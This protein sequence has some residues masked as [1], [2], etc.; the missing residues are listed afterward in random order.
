M[1]TLYLCL[2][3]CL[4]QTT[5]DVRPPPDPKEPPRVQ[6]AH[7]SVHYGDRDYPIAWDCEYELD[8]AACDQATLMAGAKHLTAVGIQGGWV[9]KLAG[10]SKEP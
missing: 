2:A 9:V 3:L 10:V 8:G 5:A 7:G 6:R 4:A 1:K